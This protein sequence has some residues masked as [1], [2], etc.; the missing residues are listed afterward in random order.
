MK[1]FQRKNDDHIEA[2]GEVDGVRFEV[3]RVTYKGK[4]AYAWFTYVDGKLTNKSE[5]AWET[6]EEA[7]NDVVSLLLPDAVSVEFE[8]PS[9]RDYEALNALLYTG[10]LQQEITDFNEGVSMYEGF[11]QGLPILKSAH[12]KMD[13]DFDDLE[14]FLAG[15][16]GAS[17]EMVANMRMMK[18]VVMTQY[19]ILEQIAERNAETLFS[20]IQGFLKL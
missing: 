14:D 4:W 16:S 19:D 10:G 11:R 20:F 12:E 3:K 18:E 17:P 15:G 5:G 1:N 7:V 13:N 8:Q 6:V 2:V 9:A